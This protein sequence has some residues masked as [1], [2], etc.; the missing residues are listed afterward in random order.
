MVELL[1][2]VALIS[3]LIALLLP[4]LQRS[5]EVA[6]RTTCATNL[7]AIH[8]GYLSYS[9]D[10]FRWLPQT[11]RGGSGAGYW[12]QQNLADV[13][14]NNYLGTYEVYYCPSALMDGFMTYPSLPAEP[15]AQWWWERWQ[16]LANYYE[17]RVT[18]YGSNCHGNPSMP[19][20]YRVRRSSVE[21]S[22]VL[23]HD[24][25]ELGPGGGVGEWSWRVAHNDNVEP[26]GNNV[27]LLG[28]SV[29]W[30]EGDQMKP[31][32]FNGAWQVWW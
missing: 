19:Q 11:T 6:R 14:V 23:V 32:W 7:K 2:V 18:G 9:V 21:P 4:A 16:Q 28:G 17:Y 5:K 30:N 25:N 31:R 22:R 29:R 13:L 8:T 3:L 27:V 10:E 26:E 12:V 24:G 15:T 20:E 1:M